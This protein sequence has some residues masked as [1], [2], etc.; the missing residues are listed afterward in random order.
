MIEPLSPEELRAF[1]DQ[2]RER[3]RRLAMPDG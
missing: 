2:V 3:L 1:R